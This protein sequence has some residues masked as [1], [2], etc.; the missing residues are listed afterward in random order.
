M[1]RKTYVLLMILLAAVACGT[2]SVKT[3]VKSLDD[4]ISDYNVSLRW[5]VLDKVESYHRGKNGEKKPL[6]RASM[7]TVRI[8]GYTILEQT[9]NAEVNEAVIKGEVDYYT[10][11]TGTL[12]KHP[13]T[14]LWWYSDVEERWYNGSDYLQIQ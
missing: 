5:S 9:I 13:F 3:K 6:D 12:K 8:T 10:T 11:N 7:A 2:T 1:N 4:A 14:H